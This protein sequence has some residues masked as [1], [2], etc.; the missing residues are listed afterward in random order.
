MSSILKLAK[1]VVKTPIVRELGWMAL[2][3][4]PNLY[5]KGTNK[6]KNKKIKKILQ[7]DL[8]ITLVNMGAEY[9]RQKLE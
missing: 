8:K 5:N 3:E 1:K 4:L 7:S 9:R 2:R 6:I